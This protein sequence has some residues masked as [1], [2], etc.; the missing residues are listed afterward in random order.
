[1]GLNQRSRMEENTR[2]VCVQKTWHHKRHVR[3]TRL[4]EE[5]IEINKEKEGQVIRKAGLKT[6]RGQPRRCWNN[7]N[8][9]SFTKK[10]SYVQFRW[11]SIQRFSGVVIVENCDLIGWWGRREWRWLVIRNRGEFV[12]TVL[13]IIWWQHVLVWRG[14]IWIFK[15]FITH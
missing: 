10:E 8:S 6:S 4:R 7:G 9:S 3:S 14:K 1:M 2:R 11:F 15:K 5:K 13:K 12:R